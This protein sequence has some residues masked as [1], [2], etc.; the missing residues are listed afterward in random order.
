M[1]V[2]TVRPAIQAKMTIHEFVKAAFYNANILLNVG[3]MPGRSVQQEFKNTLAKLGVWMYT[4]GKTICGS[5][6]AVTAP[7]PWEDARKKRISYIC[8]F[9][10]S[11]NKMT[12]FYSRTKAENT[13]GC[14]V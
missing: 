11:L 1:P 3:P 8:I 9:L 2:M 13:K 5:R 4:Y 6:G 14:I 10:T 7:K 12:S